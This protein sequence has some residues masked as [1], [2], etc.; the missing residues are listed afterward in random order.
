MLLNIKLKMRGFLR[1]YKKAVIIG[2]IIWT[3]IFAVNY[4]LKYFVTQKPETTYNPHTPIISGNSTPNKLQSKIDEVID[5]YIE[6]CNNKEYYEAYNL[7]TAECKESLF[8]K[9]SDF[10]KYASS[11]FTEKKIYTVQDYSNVDGKYIYQVKILNDILST[12][13]TGKD[14]YSY[15]DEKIVV[16]E[17]NGKLKIAVRGYIESKEDIVVAEDM[18]MKVWIEDMKITYDKTTYTIKIKNKTDY[19]IVIANFKDNSEVLMD[20]GTQTREMIKNTESMYR[21]IIIKMGQTETFDISFDKYYDEGETVGYILF[22]KIRLIEDYDREETVESEKERAEKLYSVK[23][24]L[25]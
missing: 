6:Y 24:P 23:I 2:I 12:G 22:N 1:K 11:I 9:Y 3:I 8:P 17:E 5:A 18:N 25:P 14:N 7:L 16:S 21:P 4:F 19:D 13:M 10:E 15:Y 20:L